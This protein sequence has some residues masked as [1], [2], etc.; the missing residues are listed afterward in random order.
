MGLSTP[1]LLA[2]P[3]LALGLAAGGLAAELAS[4]EEAARA[5]C[6]LHWTGFNLSPMLAPALLKAGEPVD[7]S[8]HLAGEALRRFNGE[9]AR[10]RRLK[11]E[12]ASG[13]ADLP[14]AVRQCWA[15]VGAGVSS[16]SFARTFDF[17]YN[18]TLNA[19]HE[20]VEQAVVH[21]LA[22]RETKAEAGGRSV[23][24]LGCGDGRWAA[25][26]AAA[27]MGP[28]DELMLLDL[29]G[30]NLAAAAALA[31]ASAQLRSVRMFEANMN[32]R[33]LS[34]V[35]GQSRE[36][37]NRLFD[38]IESSLMFH[39]IEDMAGLLQ[40]VSA[41]LAPAGRF[42][43]LD[44][45]DHNVFEERMLSKV[46]GYIPPFHGIEF[47]RNHSEMLALVSSA[48]LE[49]V[50]YTRV[51]PSTLFLTAVRAGGPGRTVV[52]SLNTEL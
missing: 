4:V 30:A 23:L 14:Y 22:G 16:A 38:V 40:E 46:L 11:A 49:V 13:G 26:Y 2:R 12:G 20:L 35:L 21:A 7:P 10:G 15:G 19:S 36:G 8:E 50:E 3:C 24:S 29:H 47:F 43:F 33:S 51:D 28:S 45:V 5:S 44:V 25:R 34:T 39:H 27:A 31:N 48:G 32:E 52:E 42:V 41:L 17:A 9:I 6:A 37:G 18:S 1:Q